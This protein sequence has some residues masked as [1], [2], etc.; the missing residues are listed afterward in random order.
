[1]LKYKFVIT[2]WESAGQE[3]FWNQ[4]IFLLWSDLNQNFPLC[5]ANWLGISKGGL[6]EVEWVAGITL[7]KKTILQNCFKKQVLLPQWLDN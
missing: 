7:N 1:M 5:L 3:Q 2:W 6:V 4:I